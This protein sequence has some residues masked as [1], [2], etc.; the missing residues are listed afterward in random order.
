MGKTCSPGSLALCHSPFHLDL[1]VPKKS[2]ENS[3]LRAF[4]FR[5]MGVR[6]VEFRVL[7]GRWKKRNNRAIMKKL[8]RRGRGER[9]G[10]N[11][12]KN[13]ILEWWMVGQE[14]EPPKPII[15][16]FHYSNIPI[17]CLFQHSNLFALCYCFAES[18]IFVRPKASPPPYPSP[19][20]GEGREGVISFGCGFAALW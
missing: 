11:K 17:V 13:G 1:W 6:P 14:I 20:R 10:I 8:N 12:W 19:S 16:S 9:R 2:T 15:P 3:I 5:Q 4:T 18:L 7:P